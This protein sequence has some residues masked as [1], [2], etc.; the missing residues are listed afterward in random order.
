MLECDTIFIG[1]LYIKRLIRLPMMSMK[2]FLDGCL[3]RQQNNIPVG[4][5]RENLPR[6]FLN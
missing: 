1:V 6:R 2:K 3:N 5:W 4:I